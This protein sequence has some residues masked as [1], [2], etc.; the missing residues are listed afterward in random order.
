MAGK[1]VMATPKKKKMKKRTKFTIVAVVNIIWYTV[2]V[3]VLSY[4]D[5]PVPAELTVGWYSAWTL[6]L[7]MLYGIKL[8]DHSEG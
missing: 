3:L 1:R 6:E 5:H 4:Y 2:A 8:K 7:A